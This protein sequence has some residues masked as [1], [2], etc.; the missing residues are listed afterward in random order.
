VE[1][2]PSIET[3]NHR[4]STTTCQLAV[5]R[6]RM[7]LTWRWASRQRSPPSATRADSARGLEAV[8]GARGPA[9]RPRCPARMAFGSA[10]GRREKSISL[11]VTISRQRHPTSRLAKETGIIGIPAKRP[12][13]GPRSRSPGKG[14]G[15][16]A[17]SRSGHGATAARHRWRTPSLRSDW[18][19]R[20]QREPGYVAIP[21]VRVTLAHPSRSHSTVG[22]FQRPKF[23]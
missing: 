6:R 18:V 21:R 14:A 4:P 7:S 19:V 15:A 5:T 20:H 2:P 16:F 13:I 23:E 10:Q 3:R 1:I 9:L 11:T 17:G 12:I 8:E 22:G